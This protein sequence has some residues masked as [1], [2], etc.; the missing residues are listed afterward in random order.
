MANG[1]AL[2]HDPNLGNVGENL[3]AGFSSQSTSKV[4]KSHNKEKTDPEKNQ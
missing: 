3:F 1:N 2:A 4:K